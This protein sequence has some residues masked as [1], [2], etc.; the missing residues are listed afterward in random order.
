M[1]VSFK[2]MSTPNPEILMV[3]DSMNLA[4][5]WKHKGAKEF[6]EEFI[7][8]VESLKNSYKSG[9]VV[10]ACDEGSSSYRKAIFPNYK[11]GR[12]EK[13]AT[14]TDSERLAF[15]AFLKEFQRTIDIYK[16]VDD[17]P[18]LKFPGV[19]AD[20]IAAYLVRRCKKKLSQIWLMSSDKDWDLL[21]DK[22]VSRFSY[23]TRKEIRL[24]NWG[25]HYD[26]GVDDHIS[27]KC[28]TGDSGDSI[29]GVDGI[30][31]VKAQGLVTRYG[32]TFDLIANLPIDSKYKFIANLN[33]FGR[34][35]LETNLRLMDLVTYCEEAIGEENCKEIDKVMESY[36]GS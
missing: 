17:Y 35:G 30:G 18:V 36:L 25:E 33:K 21:I 2:Q 11:S 28:L 5:R 12:K 23:V 16:E 6:A 4:F 15:E 19:E 10:I 24:D 7:S 32:S 29:P 34:Q 27:I 20:D 26:Y 22:N 9:K 3:V 31:P 8:T 1:T 13:Y 14:Q